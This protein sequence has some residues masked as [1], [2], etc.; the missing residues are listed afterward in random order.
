MKEN[1]NTIANLQLL[2]DSKNK[3]KGDTPLIDWV[4]NNA[5]QSSDMYVDSSVSLDILQFEKFIES[6]KTNLTKKLKQVLG[7]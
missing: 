6:R 1:Y 3:S 5:I 7:L 4:A 2:E